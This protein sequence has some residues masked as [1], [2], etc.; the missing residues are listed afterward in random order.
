MKY[1]CMRYLII[2]LR[3]R[4][5]KAY[6]LYCTVLYCTV[7]Y[8]TVLYC[9]VLY[10]TVLYCTVLCCAVLYMLSCDVQ[11]KGK[12]EIVVAPSYFRTQIDKV[13]LE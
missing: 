12:L 6:I 7:L 13:Q 4:A 8:C 3:L 11:C 9:T 1:Y 5:E 2:V 10:C